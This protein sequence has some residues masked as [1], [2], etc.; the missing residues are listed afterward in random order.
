MSKREIPEIKCSPT[1]PSL[2]FDMFELVRERLVETFMAAGHTQIEAERIALYVVEGV[3]C[4]PQFM[5]VL[6]RIEPPTREEII[7]VLGPVMDEAPA[8]DKAKRLLLRI[9][10]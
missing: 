10:D 8:L 5:K 1:D 6:T 4:F 3:R 2:E 9:N 7:D